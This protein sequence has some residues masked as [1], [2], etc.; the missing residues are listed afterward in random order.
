[1][2]Q[3]GIGVA[4]SF[5][6]GPAFAQEASSPIDWSKP[7]IGV[8]G[9]IPRVPDRATPL[10]VEVYAIDDLKAVGSPGVEEFTRSLTLPAQVCEPQKPAEQTPCPPPQAGSALSPEMR[11]KLNRYLPEALQGQ[12]P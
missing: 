3:L 9:N 8:D 7:V 11:E 1:M 4:C 10:A 12:A 2:R 6:A 5:L